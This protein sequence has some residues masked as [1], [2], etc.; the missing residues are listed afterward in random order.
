MGVAQALMELAS[1]GKLDERSNW[2]NLIILCADWLLDFDP[3]TVKLVVGL[4]K[5]V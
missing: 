1:S 5:L 3:R 2:L 4:S